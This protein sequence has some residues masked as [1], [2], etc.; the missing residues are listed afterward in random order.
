MSA[1]NLKDTNLNI[2]LT[3]RQMIKRPPKSALTP[4]R[5]GK[6]NPIFDATT[7]EDQSDIYNIINP[8][9]NEGDILLTARNPSLLAFRNKTQASRPKTALTSARE[10]RKAKKEAEIISPRNFSTLISK[11]PSTAM[12]ESSRRVPETITREINT[13][14][15][16][17]AFDE[18]PIAYF[19]KRK[20]GRGHRFI[21]LNHVGDRSDPFFNPY[22][23]TKVPFAEVNSEYFTMS[24]NGVTHVISSGN[25][26]HISLDRWSKESMLFS[27]IRKLK[28][29]AQFFYWKPFRIWKN[30]VMRQR[31]NELS[32]SIIAHP[33]FTHPGFFQTQLNILDIYVE[34]ESKMTVEVMLEKH[35]LAFAREKKYELK[36]YFAEIA[37]NVD[38]LNK[39]YAEYIKSI[40]E[41]ILALDAKIRDPRILQ[42]KDSDFP[43]I[44][45]RNPNLAQLMIL[46]KKKAAKRVELTKMVN[47]QI[48]ALGYFIRDIDYMLL[49]AIADSTRDCWRKASNI[50]FSDNSAVFQVQVSFSDDGKVVFS[51]TLEYLTDS[52]HNSLRGSLRTA[53][54]LPRLLTE[55]KLRPHIRESHP[56]FKKLI[57]IGPKIEQMIER[58]DELNKIEN[59]IIEYITESYKKAEMEAQKFTDFYSIYEIG[60]SWDVRNYITTRS[61]KPYDFV[62][63]SEITGAEGDINF[64]D[65][66]IVNMRSVRQDIQVFTNDHN[67]L[68]VF[69]PT[70][71]CNAIYINSRSLLCELKP[72]PM[73]TLETL[74]STLRTLL[75]E[76]VDRIKNALANYSKELK[77]EPKN[78]Q[79]FVHYCELITK[80]SSLQPTIQEEIN[81]IDDMYRLF[82]AFTMRL[83]VTEENQNPL[84]PQMQLF[85]TAQQVA[86]SIKEQNMEHFTRNLKEMTKK[87]ETKLQKYL[88]M[89]SSQP[90]S[91]SE[92]EPDRLKVDIAQLREKVKKVNPEIKTYLHYQ[93][94][95]GIKYCDFKSLHDVID[96][97]DFDERLFTAVSKWQLIDSSS[98]KTPF[99]TIDIDEFSSAVLDLE[100]D[101]YNLNSLTRLPTPLLSELTTRLNSVAP[102]LEQ[103]KQ[104]A[105]SNMQHRHWQVLFEECGL[106]GSYHS[107]IKL[108]EIVQLGI[109]ADKDRIDSETRVAVGE[110]QLEEEFKQI[111]NRWCAV[112][113]PILDGQTKSEDSLLLDNVENMISEIED[114]VLALTRMCSLPFVH[115]VRD[116]VSKLQSSLENA[117]L[118]L[119]AWQL[120][121][122]NWVLLSSLFLHEDT[123]NALQQQSTRFNWVRRRWVSIIRHTSKDLSLLI[124]CQFPSLLEMLHENNSALEGIL[125]SLGLFVDAKR[126]VLPR[127]FVLGNYDVLQLVSF[128]GFANLRPII[129]R[130]F[131]GMAD[132]DTNDTDHTPASQQQYQRV[133]IHGLICP[134]KESIMFSKNLLISGSIEHWMPSLIEMMKYTFT[135]GFNGLMNKIKSLQLVDWI[136]NTPTHMMY[137]ALQVLFTREVDEC[138]NQ[139]ET[140]IHSFENY[141][142]KLFMKYQ[143]VSSLLDTPL[144]SSEIQK[145]G[146]AL[147]VLS[148]FIEVIKFLGV[149]Q[150]RK[151]WWNQAP[152]IRHSSESQKMSI[153]INDD[154]IDFGW[155]LWGSIR[156]AILTP[157]MQRA[158]HIAALDKCSMI[159]G[160]PGTGRRTCVESLAML[161]GRYLFHVPAFPDFSDN[162][163]SRIVAGASMMG[164]WACFADIDQLPYNAVSH[165]YDVV[166]AY[167]EGL[168]SSSNRI[169]IDGRITELNQASRIFFTACAI[170]TELPPQFRTKAKPVA[171]SAPERKIIIEIKLTANGFKSAKAVAAKLD[172][173]VPSVVNSF[174]QDLYTSSSFGHI[175][176]IIEKMRELLREVKYPT[177]TIAFDSTRASEEYV[178]ARA[179]YIHFSNFLPSEYTKI[180]LQML[181]NCFQIF[182][183]FETFKGKIVNPNCFKEENEIN[184][185]AST[186]KGEINESLPALYIENQTI[187]LFTLLNSHRVVIIHGPPNSGKSKVLSILKSSVSKIIENRQNKSQT[188]NDL[189]LIKRIKIEKIF[190]GSDS[191]VRNFGNLISDPSTG[192]IRAHGK[193]SSAINHLRDN[194]EGAMKILLFDGP[195]THEFQQ[196]ISQLASQNMSKL[197]S[198]DYVNFGDDFK[199]VI[200]TTK[201]DELSPYIIPYCG[202]LPMKHVIDKFESTDT[203]MILARVFNHSLADKVREIFGEVINLT[204]KYLYHIENQ[205]CY[206]D[207]KEIMKDGNIILV[208]RLPTHSAILLRGMIESG[209]VDV[210]FKEQVN[211]GVIYSTFL[212]FSGILNVTQRNSFDSWIRS[213]F[214]IVLS[215]DWSEF[216]VPPHFSDI[217]PRPCLSSHRVINGNLAPHD[218]VIIDQKAVNFPYSNVFI[219]NVVVPTANF[220]ELSLIFKAY[221]K[222]NQSILLSGPFG[223][224]SFLRFFFSTETDYQPI[225]IPTSSTKTAEAIYNFIDIHTTITTKFAT[226]SKKIVFIFEDISPNNSQVMEFIR[227]ILTTYS[228]TLYSP[229]DPKLYEKVDLHD[230]AVISTTEDLS[231]L[232]ARFISL[233]AL[234]QILPMQMEAVKYVLTN[235]FTAFEVSPV[236]TTKLLNFLNTCM[237]QVDG[238]PKTLPNLCRLID[239]ICRMEERKASND[240]ETETLIRT[241]VSEINSYV[242]AA[243]KNSINSVSDIV[244]DFYPNSKGGT[245]LKDNENFFYSE[246]SI[247][248]ENALVVKAAAHEIHFIREELEFYLQVYNN[249][250]SEKIVL[251]FFT[252][253]MKT[254]ALLHRAFTCPGGH[255]IIVGPEGSGRFTLTRFV[256]HMSEFD[257]VHINGKKKMQCDNNEYLYA[258]MRDI[259]TNSA[260]LNKKSILFI[261]QRGSRISQDLQIVLDFVRNQDFTCFFSK[262]GLEDLYIKFA[263]GQQQR[264][265]QRYAIFNQIRHVIKMNFHLSIAINNEACQLFNDI[266]AVQVNIEDFSHEELIDTAKYA[267]SPPI[268]TNVLGSYLHHIPQIIEH[269]HTLA[270]I[271]HSFVRLNH[272]YDFI[273]SFAQTV[274]ADY[275]EL[276]TH[277]GHLVAALRFLGSLEE[278]SQNIDRK[279]DV[280]APNLQRLT[281]D[282]DAL[283]VSFSSKKEAIETRRKQISEE[284]K[285]KTDAVKRAQDEV[286]YLE[287]SVASLLPQVLNSQKQ[288]EELTLNDIETIRINA[289]DPSPSLKLMLEV[290]CI[291]LDY[292]I[293]YD[294]GGYKLLM[295]NDFTQLLLSRIKYQ[296][297]PV[298]VLQQVMPYFDDSSFSSKE[299]GTVAPALQ[300]IYEW[301]SSICKHAMTSDK[302]I[303]KKDELEKL[304]IQF[305]ETV[306]EAKLEQQSISQVEEQ[307]EEEI[308]Y[309]DN[310]LSSKQ[311]TES[312]YEQINSKKQNIDAILNNM[313]GLIERWNT[314]SSSVSSQREIIVGDSLIYAFYISYCGMFDDVDKSSLLKNVMDEVKGAG[315]STSFNDPIQAITDRFLKTNYTDSAF[316]IE[317]TYVHDAAL[318]LYHINAT[319]R[320]PLVIDPDMLIEFYF[321]K[322]KQYKNLVIASQTNQGLDSIISNA[323]SE[324]R[325]LLLFDVD[326][327]HPYVTPLLTLHK[328]GQSD[329]LSKEIRIGTKM[330]TW[331]PKFKLIMFTN[332]RNIEDIPIELLVRSSVVDVS[333]SSLLAMRSILNNTFVEFYDPNSLSILIEYQRMEMECRVS[334]DK[335]EREILESIADAVSKST[336][337]PGMDFLSNEELLR[338]ILQSKDLYFQAVSRYETYE[339]NRGQVLKITSPFSI[340]IDS[341]MTV[342][343]AISRYLCRLSSYNSFS[344]AAFVT[345][346]A[347]SLQMPGISKQ[348]SQSP[349]NQLSLGLQ[350][351]HQVLNWVFP[352]ISF[353]DSVV[354]MFI[355]VFLRD[356]N[357]EKIR[358]N[359]L[360]VICRHLAEEHNSSIDLGKVELGIG[361]PLEHMKFT[362][363]RNVFTFVQRYIAD[364]FGNEF[365]NNIPIFQ[366]ENI[367]SQNASM[368]T[369]IMSSPN[370]NPSSLIQLYISLKTR[371]DNFEPISLYSSSDHLKNVRKVVTSAMSRGTRVLLHVTQPSFEIASLL[372]DV[373]STMLNTS[374]HTNFRLMVSCNSPEFLPHRLIENSRKLRYSDFPSIRHQILQI[375]HHHSTSIRSSTNPKAV[376]KLAYATALSYSLLK[377]RQILTPLSYASYFDIRNTIFR[378]IFEKM[379]PIID[380]SNVIPMSVIRDYIQ[381]NCFGASVIDAFDRRKIRSLVFSIF[382]NNFLDDDFAYCSGY[383]DSDRYQMPMEMPLSN[384]NSFAQKM[385]VF[386]SA[387]GLL[388]NRSCSSCVRDWMLSRWITKGIIKLSPSIKTQPT[389][390][391]LDARLD[392]YIMSLPE[393]VDLKMLN[394]YVSLSPTLQVLKSEAE[395]FNNVII[396]IKNELSASELSDEAEEL[397]L[398]TAPQKWRSWVLYDASKSSPRFLSFLSEKREFLNHCITT[399]AVE[400][401]DVRL[402]ANL[403][404]LL[405]AYLYEVAIKRGMPADSATIE[406]STLEKDQKPPP[407]FIVL[408]GVH[409]FCGTYS[410]CKLVINSQ[411]RTVQEF[412]RILC[413]VSKAVQRGKDY[414][415]CPLYRTLYIDH[416][417]RQ[418]V[419]NYTDGQADNLI[420]YVSLRSDC[421]QVELITNHTSLVCV[422][423]EQFAL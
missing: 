19:S 87:L 44:K 396:K 46:E 368:P 136:I 265:E 289:D 327:L 266:G 34:P 217:Y 247:N 329:S 413:S 121:Q 401:V 151:H 16:S 204:I 360:D 372:S 84:P 344:Y 14:K 321:T 191:W 226:S 367:I 13:E 420:W 160:S 222:Q 64:D 40:T 225:F 4:R 7:V 45:R 390:N 279:L 261:R 254:W 69:H 36:D 299:M 78:L 335:H 95:L 276:F 256:A 309:L 281:M 221:M 25:T 317:Q 291:F 201:I 231:K 326:T 356:V 9:G 186:I 154:I 418:S 166:Y 381:D 83:D 206:A 174:K 416:N 410:N 260:L 282:V 220:I 369:L 129:S 15:L 194:S 119:Q 128:T 67:R 346:V 273:D 165:L 245:D 216:G 205:V 88:D 189:V 85:I 20:D 53:G 270:T 97:L 320:A 277:S 233:F 47:G 28:M 79:Q 162:V 120:F 90:S 63:G 366:V 197:N 100:R 393:L 126:A 377:Y 268:Y 74:R 57:E 293:S 142:K 130:L 41:A 214:H 3:G 134:N 184:I 350:I 357:N 102:Y 240:N 37:D 243:N 264:P 107:D 1:F 250:A 35:L 395:S 49:E 167:S 62:P 234:V 348:N 146:I 365:G 343:K 108:D 223:K 50:I 353:R 164:A 182:D 383:P 375:Y 208:D 39:Y 140:N 314:E 259:V 143:E 196:F 24:A 209:D 336:A 27:T 23:L 403:R 122:R 123:K 388:M 131:M 370:H 98:M 8:G 271:D 415:M 278:E 297:I 145:A 295:D 55:I 238:F 210:N 331:D 362:N 373:Y 110:S 252:P 99:S 364:M 31:Y 178:A 394:K 338:D 310:S 287:N 319:M 347:N 387:D 199:I 30:F 163:I 290:L 378:D 361:D 111:Q 202:I 269:L 195:L 96:T 288:I 296:I 292:P 322:S 176:S 417:S 229:S 157:S 155:E 312:E 198:F 153:V 207:S 392:G 172:S 133:R 32:A 187:D 402:F 211:I 42:V 382:A 421:S 156:P 219:N 54:N 339:Q 93:E 218:M 423:P 170:P 65:E 115:G 116:Q 253:V 358:L 354:L 275:Q 71:Y 301:I 400:V 101:L 73:N 18:D 262:Q 103:I 397:L 77:I 324:G 169:N 193:I 175:T 158:V 5:V 304:E 318:D 272:Y 380:N 135:D 328:L 379:R 239:L 284:L 215:T 305:N 389:Q 113:L 241:M 251:K 323:I 334:K 118:I 408:S 82:G 374:L 92:A 248:S 298:T 294:R 267:L 60:K 168:A 183:N 407:N 349:E 232:P 257:F 179:S 230:F 246:F 330:T 274:S 316:N 371:G 300:N 404:G 355:I 21:Y 43:E 152:K 12:R 340:V 59:K 249:S 124:V 263:S 224:T 236:F 22:Q 17:I 302:L 313:E 351:I 127:L 125:A 26:E 86:Q 414:Y 190:N 149:D 161:Y 173:F 109:L 405:H 332:H 81:F 237:L 213:S 70:T 181:F 58:D 228:L 255:A 258:I 51:P 147:T 33:F 80:T 180:L 61:G 352:S 76:K 141:E 112:Q 235:I 419:Q 280:I 376:K 137:L 94:V 72:I 333:N 56:D 212:A 341:V 106:P 308:K 139:L 144:T 138:F 337:N 185:L 342:W 303:K 386:A 406:F 200:E 159:L 315:F 359:D 52:I 104:L 2:P 422:M 391:Q 242:C 66:P 227:M 385:P 48:I 148:N 307:L 150:T 132:V 325:T 117:A 10:K 11:R 345:V 283:Q 68:D 311:T 38:K 188:E 203:D 244:K 105:S 114:A 399:A 398:G 6:K 285:E 91:I 177:F 409:L 286:E 412:P 411:S 75:N 29:F 306:E 363:I 384:Y 171:L 192:S 89:A